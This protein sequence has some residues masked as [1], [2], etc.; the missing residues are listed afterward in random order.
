MRLEGLQLSSIYSGG[1]DAERFRSVLRECRERTVKTQE[2]LSAAT[3]DEEEK[4]APIDTQTISNIERGVTKDPSILTVARLVEAMGLPLSEFFLQI[5][6][7]TDADSIALR[8]SDTTTHTGVGTAPR[9]ANVTHGGHPS[10]RTAAAADLADIFSD[11]ADK[12]MEARTRL[13]AAQR[14]DREAGSPQRRSRTAKTK[15]PR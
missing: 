2:A 6:R 3:A 1:V 9:A 10:L 12:F 8:Q 15:R 5:E 7:Q 4:I 14:V 13:L 11:I